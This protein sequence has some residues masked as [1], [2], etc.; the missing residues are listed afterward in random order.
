MPGK[1]PL[2]KREIS[3]KPEITQGLQNCNRETP[4]KGPDLEG[5]CP[6]GSG[7]ILTLTFGNVNPLTHKPPALI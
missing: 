1:A 4:L 3:K 6:Q 2:L 5:L 7:L